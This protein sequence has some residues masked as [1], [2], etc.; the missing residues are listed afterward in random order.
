[1]LVEVNFLTPEFYI[2]EEIIKAR[3]IANR[4]IESSD[5]ESEGAGC[6]RRN[7]PLFFINTFDEEGTFLSC[8]FHSQIF[9]AIMYIMNRKILSYILLIFLYFFASTESEERSRPTLKRKILT[10]KRTPEHSGH[11]RVPLSNSSRLVSQNSPV[12]SNI[13]VD[14][15]G[16]KFD[17]W[18]TFVKN[19]LL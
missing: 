7:A 1:M 15:D 8:P 9:S 12:S 10:E 2:S 3:C 11:P 17:D 6:R 5:V 16:K 19:E 14:L 13:C 18:L 4:Y